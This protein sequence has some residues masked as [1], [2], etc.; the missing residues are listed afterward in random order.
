MSEVIRCLSIG[1]LLVAAVAWGDGTG[2]V[3]GSVQAEGAA[4]ELVVYVEKVAAASPQPVKGRSMVQKHS[5]FRPGALVVTVGSNVD[6]PNQDKIFHNVFSLSPGNEFDLGLYRG[7]ATKAVEMKEP[8]EVDVFCNIHPEMAAKILVLQNE[9]YAP[10]RKDGRY[11][12]S[13]L[14]PGSYT[15]VA[16]SPEHVPVKQ[17]VEIRAGATASARFTL[18]RRPGNR[19]H[20]N[21]NG[22]Q[23]GRY[24]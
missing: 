24:K 19:A 18:V 8:G 9:F 20:L 13:G 7:G 10:V 22:E 21:K 11:E 12:I 1:T 5:A 3:A 6:F 4:S 15:V 14:P 17:K 16:W 2:K 23:Y